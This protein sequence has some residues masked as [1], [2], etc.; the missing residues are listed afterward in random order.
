MAVIASQLVARVATE[1]VTKAKQDLSEMGTA[2]QGAQGHMSSMGSAAGSALLGIGVAAGVAAVAV[3]VTAVKAAGDFQSSMS[4]LVNAAGE[5]AKNLGMVSDG[6]L[7]LAVDTGTSTK[8]LSEGMFNVESAS[9]HGADGLKVL[10]AAAKGA[11]V[12]HA[13]L[14]TATSALT[15]VMTDY[16]FEAD[17]ATAVMNMMNAAS[18]AGKM[19]LQDLAASMG[20]VLPIASALGISFP[21]VGAA[22]AVMTNAGQSAQESTQQL[23]NTI[24]SLAAP[25]NVAEK[26]MQSVG[27][28]AQQLKDTL[29][30]EGLAASIALIEEH[31]GKTF[32]EGS[33]E[34]VNAFQDIMGG[35]TGYNT[36][37]MLGGKN[38]EA[39]K[40]NIA[41]ITAALNAGGN[42]IK[43][44]ANVQKDW[45][46]KVSQGQA[47]AETFMIKLGTGLLPILSKVA[48]VMLP[49]AAAFSNWVFSGQAAHDIMT[50]LQPV[51]AYLSPLITQLGIALQQLGAVIMP[52]VIGFAQW[53]QSSGALKLYIS[54][55]VI[56]VGMFIQGLTL[57]A[58]GLTN[59]IVFFSTSGSNAKVLW[60]ILASIASFLIST[61]KPVIDQLVITFNTQLK[62][63]WDNLV[64]AF[65]PA[66]PM[67]QL[68][69]VVIGGIVVVA[70]S[71]LVGLLSGV[72]Q[73][74]AGL[75]IGLTQTFGGIVQIISGGMQTAFAIMSFFVHLFT[76]QF[77]QLGGDLQRIWTGIATFFVGIWN[78]IAGV[79][80][81]AFGLILGFLS[82]FATGVVGVFTNIYNILVGHSIIPELCAAI[83]MYFAQLPGQV[84]THLLN[85]LSVAVSI[86]ASLAAQA[87]SQS[88]SLVNGVI[89]Q[90]AQMAGRASA[91][92]GGVPGAILGI[93][94][95]AA[96][97]AWNAGAIIVNQIAAGIRAAI[98]NVAGAI[99]S[100]TDYIAAHLPHSPAKIGPLRDLVKQGSLITEQIG[101]GMLSSLPKLQASLNMVVQ[102]ISDTVG[103]QGSSS[104]AFVGVPSAQTQGGSE[105]HVHNHIYL[106]GREITDIVMTRAVQRIRAQGGSAVTL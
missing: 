35:A 63:A 17:Q 39:Y 77:D 11:K 96:N 106:D 79:F 43:G 36:A 90:L 38:M 44:W 18:G 84:G 12:G 75:L 9:F 25:S 103:A 80:S 2:A 3:G 56:E 7:K 104:P 14:A 70:L 49:A 72:A 57:L 91:A 105:I 26:A 55:L 59:V 69:G 47:I 88:I 64:K 61:F 54:A 85:L 73:G 82:G 86:L 31:V 48:D 99:Q 92:L 37:L 66:I 24:R 83:I 52:L 78:T 97:D 95:Q 5:S 76:L 16:H 4:G 22:I 71:L 74:F 21:D 6:I 89:A 60:G 10:E 46:Q 8:E 81:A 68:F 98:G 20:T 50:R 65:Q 41:S 29:S 87:I 58:Q 1:G 34:A 93:L 51:I 15:T 101:E 28:S 67:L 94:A 32:P 19:E 33:V 102:P 13:E 42:E 53:L 62:P 23:A 27:L 100:V 30:K 40:T 45:N